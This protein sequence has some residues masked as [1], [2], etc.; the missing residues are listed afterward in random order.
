MD[1]IDGLVD[2]AHLLVAQPLPGGC[3]VALVGNSGGPLIL[4]ADAC[5]AA[6]LEVVTLGPQC[7][8]RRGSMCSARSGSVSS[9]LPRR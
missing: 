3:R 9:W 1:D 7:P 5:E 8:S 4:A 6:G 2:V